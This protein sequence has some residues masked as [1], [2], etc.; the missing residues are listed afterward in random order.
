MYRVLSVPL[1][2]ILMGGCAATV[3]S[4]PRAA[5]S[6]GSPSEQWASLQALHRG[7]PVEVTLLTRA[8]IAGEFASVDDRRIAIV[9]HDGSVEVRRSDVQRIT[10][11]TGV[12]RA[13]GAR[14][15]FLVGAAAGAL[16]AAATVTSNRGPWMMMMSAG[17]GSLGALV[18]SLYGSNGTTT[19]IYQGP[20]PVAR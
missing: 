9:S 14:W 8:S 7:A 17:W 11:V 4:A 12:T 10:V 1:L 20:T 5:R 18:G 19:V 3:V 15:G 13:D 2:A 16:L 6:A